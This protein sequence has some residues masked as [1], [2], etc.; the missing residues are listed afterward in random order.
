MASVASIFHCLDVLEKEFDKAF[1][2][3]DVLI[4]EADFE[5]NEEALCEARDKMKVLSSC[6]SQLCHKTQT[7]AQSNA[8]LEVWWFY[9]L[10]FAAINF[11]KG[12]GCRTAYGSLNLKLYL[13]VSCNVTVMHDRNV[14]GLVET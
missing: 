5:E 9:K 10:E 12:S 3:L 2:D 8:K 7:T 14:V 6:F 11:S 4:G 13:T 1:V